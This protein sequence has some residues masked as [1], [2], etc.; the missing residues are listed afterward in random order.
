M[1]DS[2]RN[3]LPMREYHPGIGGMSRESPGIDH[4]RGD[5]AKGELYPYGLPQPP[6]LFVFGGTGWGY[7]IGCSV[8]PFFGIGAGYGLPFGVIFGAGTGVGGVCG[9]GFGTG[10]ILGVGTAY[11]PAGF[12]VSSF[13]APKWIGIERA[14]ERW[15]IRKYQEWR[16]RKKHRTF[17]TFPTP[18]REFFSGI[19]NRITPLELPLENQ[20]EPDTK[21]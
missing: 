2:P 16:N 8:G 1:D 7:G 21:P 5:G 3:G 9:V 17:Y 13:Y 20:M 6:K 10:L 15:R 19:L 11:V 18:I 12:N 14:V 4:I